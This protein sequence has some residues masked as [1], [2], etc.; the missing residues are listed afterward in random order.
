M[1]TDR[2]YPA[3]NKVSAALTSNPKAGRVPSRASGLTRAL[4]DVETL[5]GRVLLSIVPA[6]TAPPDQQAPTASVEKASGP[7]TVGDSIFV[8]TVDYQDNVAVAG[9]TIDSSDV[10]V[11]GPNNFAED[12]RYV[13]KAQPDSPSIQAMYAIDAPNRGGFTEK[14]AGT[15]T[16]TML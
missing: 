10:L 14:D 16:V 1:P 15:Y 13:G 2:R 11:R 5:E 9:Q 12:A 4:M 8:F 3:Q 6:A 7:A